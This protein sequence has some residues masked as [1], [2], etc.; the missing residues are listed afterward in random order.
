M[1]VAEIRDHLAL[2][3]PRPVLR[4]VS[5]ADFLAMEIPPRE[6][7]L[8]PWLPVKG[9]AMI[10]A[11]TGVGKTHLALEASYAVAAGANFLGWQ[12]PTPRRVLFVDGEMPAV[13]LQERI[14]AI[15]RR[16]DAEPPPGGFRVL[17]ADL[18]EAG[19]PDLSEPEG[20]AA[21]AEHFG[22]AE[23]I[24][25]DNLSTLF[26]SGKENEAESWAA[27]QPFL[28]GL[29]RQGRAGLLIHH[30]GKGG[31]QRGTSKRL[32]VL[33][34]VVRLARPDD[35]NPAQ[36]ARFIVTFDKARGFYGRDADP[37]EAWLDPVT[38]SWRRLSVQDNRDQEIMALQAEGLSG[39]KIARQLGMSV[40]TVARRI[41]RLKDEGPGYDAP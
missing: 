7:I 27:V 28:L 21:L 36:G 29:R 18:H 24:V 5:V 22:D 37:F 13:A 6:Q 20:Q 10:F 17:S 12:A 11:K 9:L 30:A 32:D 16:Y 14:A 2:T 41:A 39:R 26:R 4:P 8:A 15:A 34:T 38:S 19:L 3:L 33:D 23:L 31:E 25:L 1:R 40:P 35:Y